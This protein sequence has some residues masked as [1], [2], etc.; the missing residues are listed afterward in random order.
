VDPRVFSAMEA[1]LQ[2]AGA[3]VDRVEVAVP[4]PDVYDTV[5]HG[6]R[7]MDDV[8]GLILPAQRTGGGIECVDIAVPA[9]EVDYSVRD[10]WTREVD[11]K[12]VRNGLRGG[13]HAVQP[14]GLEAPLTAGRE[15]PAHD[16]RTGVQRVEATI[17]ATRIQHTVNNRWTGGH[18]SAGGVFPDLMTRRRIYRVDIAVVPTEVDQAVRICRRRHDTVASRK[19]PLDPM[20]LARPVGREHA[21]VR[22]VAPEDGLRVH[23]GRCGGTEKSP[24]AQLPF[25]CGAGVRRFSAMAA[26]A[27]PC[28]IVP[29]SSSNCCSRPSK[30]MPPNSGDSILSSPSS[31]RTRSTDKAC[32]CLPTIANFTV[33]AAPGWLVSSSVT[34]RA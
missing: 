4:A 13:Q 27:P 19:D 1:P 32:G 15:L 9:A 18:R 26:S 21:G 16:S 25:H 29:R 5:R 20:E 8:T 14:S 28:S 23:A 7:G 31:S 30:A 17:V 10:R 34:C 3:G 12:G 22:V 24:Q 33:A 6:R 11:V 2:C